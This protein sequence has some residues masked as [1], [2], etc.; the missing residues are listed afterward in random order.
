MSSKNDIVLEHVIDI[1]GIKEGR[2]VLEAINK[3]MD[4]A[5]DELEL[6]VHM[7]FV[8][9]ELFLNFFIFMFNFLQT[10]DLYIFSHNIIIQNY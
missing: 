3:I 10:F 7:L 8:G 1:Q 6:E 9:H 2:L 4:L 5:S